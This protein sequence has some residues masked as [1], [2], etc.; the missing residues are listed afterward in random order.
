MFPLK[1]SEIAW[2]TSNAIMLKFLFV[3]EKADLTLDWIK[4]EHL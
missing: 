3:G 4:D 2:E 1:K